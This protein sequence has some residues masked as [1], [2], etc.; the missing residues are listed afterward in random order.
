ML[1]M[2]CWHFIQF[3]ILYSTHNRMYSRWWLV[4]QLLL[5]KLLDIKKTSETFRTIFASAFSSFRTTQYLHQLLHLLENLFVHLK[6]FM[7]TRTD[8]S[9][10]SFE[11][12]INKYQ[13][14]GHQP[15]RHGD[16]L[17]PWRNQIPIL[18]QPWE[19]GPSKVHF[20]TL[21]CDLPRAIERAPKHKSWVFQ[22]GTRRF[23]AT[24]LPQL[25]PWPWG[26]G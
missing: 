1:V 16:V 9:C 4:F 24:L 26:F 19:L 21:P 17:C 6:S 3:S 14:I 13:K 5:W 2:I 20:W 11:V 25:Q 8:E 18:R 12:H 23:S 15:L 10:P 7:E 22:H